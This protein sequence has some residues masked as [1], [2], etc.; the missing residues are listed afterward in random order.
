M[1]HVHRLLTWWAGVLIYVIG[2]VMV[3]TQV[4]AEPVMHKD[5]DE[6]LNQ[7][8]QKLDTL[9]D[10]VNDLHLTVTNNDEVLMLSVTCSDQCDGLPCRQNVPR[11][12]ACREDFLDCVASCLGVNRVRGSCDQNVDP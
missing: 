10:G 12:C 2:M 6:K 1:L 4:S 7:M 9:Q 11:T 3:Q 8:L 5:L